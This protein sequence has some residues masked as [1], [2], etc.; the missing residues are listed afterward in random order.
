[1]SPVS[2]TLQSACHFCASER[3][4]RKG[5]GEKESRRSVG[6]R[7]PPP[8]SAS[9]RHFL[10]PLL[11]CLVAPVSECWRPYLDDSCARLK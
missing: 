3:G 11:N 4:G 9:L 10:H 1:M 8:P 7:S 2:A 5:E 6:R